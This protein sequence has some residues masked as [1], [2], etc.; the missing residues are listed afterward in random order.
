MLWNLERGGQ[1]RESH[2]PSQTGDLF[3]VISSAPPFTNKRTICWDR[4]S[5][6]CTSLEDARRSPIMYELCQAA[7]GVTSSYDALLEL[8]EFLGNFLRRLEAYT[9][10]PP[11]AI[12][13]DMIVKIIVKVLSVLALA[14]KQVNQGR[15]SKFTITY[16]F[17]LWVNVP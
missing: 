5:S 9:S 16:P 12:M 3:N 1:P 4:Y 15:F 13:T 8:F 17:F 14:T 7:S 10:I 6:C 2:M 11:S